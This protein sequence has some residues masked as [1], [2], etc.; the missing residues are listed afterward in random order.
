[1]RSHDHP[2]MAGLTRHKFE[3]LMQEGIKNKCQFII[4]DTRKKLTK[5][6]A[7]MYYVDL[8]TKGKNPKVVKDYFNLGSGTCRK[9]RGFM[10]KAKKGTT[11]LGA[12][13]TGHKAV[14]Y[15]KRNA[16]Y[17]ALRKKIKK[18]TKR[19]WAPALI[20]FGLQKTN[21]LAA[22][23]A[24]YIHVSPYGSS[25]GCPSVHWKNHYMISTLAKNGPSL[26]VHYG[27]KMEDIMKCTQ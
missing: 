4:N 15:F 18:K 13:I 24:K 19:Y 6:R 1:M 26:I 14:D 22:K 9:G 20:N 25:L 8:C 3:D 5:C 7:R 2:T 27:K 10:N 12:F 11:L 17:N 23:H 16:S 21:H